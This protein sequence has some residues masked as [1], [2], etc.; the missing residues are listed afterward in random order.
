MNYKFGKNSAKKLST[1]HTDLQ[2]IMNL[3]ISRSKV[4]FGISE[5]HRSKSRQYQLFQ[6]GKSKIDGY[7]KIGK[8]N[9]IPSEAADIFAYHPNLET[10][11][12]IAY[13]RTTLGYIAGLIDSCANELYTKGETSNLIR[14]GANWD[15]DG[16]IDYDQS[17]DDYPHFELIKPKL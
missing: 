11:R 4:D 6:E 17:F 1:C 14:W 13:D 10:R 15:S 16:I 12:K 9:K 7:K 2:K 5:G 3:A 8:H